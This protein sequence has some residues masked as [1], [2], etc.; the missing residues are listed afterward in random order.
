MVFN[1][2]GFYFDK[3]DEAF[4]ENS[5]EKRAEE[6]PANEK[7]KK[8]RGSRVKRV[9]PGAN[10]D[11]LSRRRTEYDGADDQSKSNFKSISEL[12]GAISKNVLRRSRVAPEES[13]EEQKPQHFQHLHPQPPKGSHRSDDDKKPKEKTKNPSAEKFLDKSVL[14]RICHCNCDTCRRVICEVARKFRGVSEV[15]ADPSTDLVRVTGRMDVKEL[16]IHLK[17]ELKKNV[18]V[19]PAEKT[20]YPGKDREYDR[21]SNIMVHNLSSK[22]RVKE[23]VEPAKLEEKFG[24][25]NSEN[26]KL[27]LPQLKANHGSDLMEPHQKIENSGNQKT[28]KERSS[29]LLLRIEKHCNCEGCTK[30]MKDIFKRFKA[31]SHPISDLYAGVGSV[32]IYTDKELV[33]VTGTMDTNELVVY[34]EEKLRRNVEVMPIQNDEHGASPTQKHRAGVRHIANITDNA[35]RKTEGYPSVQEKQNFK[36]TKLTLPQPRKGDGNDN[37]VTGT[38]HLKI[39]MYCLEGCP[40]RTQKAARKFTG[41]RSVKVEASKRLVIVV[42]TINVKELVA[43]LKQK[44]KRSVEV[45]HIQ[46]HSLPGDNKEVE[47]TKIETLKEP[48]AAREDGWHKD[49]EIKKEVKKEAEEIKNKRKVKD[50]KVKGKKYSHHDGGYDGTKEDKE[51]KKGNEGVEDN[52]KEA[53]G[54]GYISYDGEK[55]RELE[56]E[57]DRQTYFQNYG[58]Q[59]YLGHW[60][61]RIQILSD[62]NPNSCAVM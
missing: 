61:S 37:E 26:S 2:K 58:E 56:R 40:R 44:L 7:S 16:L 9:V 60:L 28:Q 62:E 51:N 8:T 55:H 47:V 49:V 33:E 34:L 5:E 25:Q 59:D 12:G 30:K 17:K 42:G 4:G 48:A 6:L 45:V 32:K 36:K 11:T 39:E 31:A 43:D 35:S 19:V 23:K 52:L 50:A 10:A 14:L 21:D 15:S 18:E 3:E 22:S 20:D 29:Q 13:F 1:C 53:K 57:G 24:Q 27:S 46:N 41:V 38:V 54:Q